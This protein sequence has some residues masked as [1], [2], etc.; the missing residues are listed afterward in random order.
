[1]WNDDSFP[2]MVWKS[3]WCSQYQQVEET[4][5][6]LPVLEF[7]CNRGN[8]HGGPLSFLF[9]EIELTPSGQWRLPLKTN[10]GFPP[11]MR[12][13]ENPC[14]YVKGY[15]GLKA[16]GLYSVLY[17]ECINESHVGA[18][19]QRCT[20]EREGIYFFREN[21]KKNTGY[22]A[23]YSVLCG[24]NIAYSFVAEL[25]VYATSIRSVPGTHGQCVV[26]AGEVTFT[27]LLIDAT[28]LS[29]MPPAST[30]RVTWSPVEEA[31]PLAKGILSSLKRD[32]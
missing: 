15:H 20:K 10:G 17:H 5:G 11:Q 2:N 8:R 16:G 26:P 29:K 13:S 25:R 18:D 24:A 6:V 9:N 1:M 4:P 21:E 30:V 32:L 3:R 12:A 7:L 22:Y 14:D 19:G 31:H 28:H 23:H 27:A